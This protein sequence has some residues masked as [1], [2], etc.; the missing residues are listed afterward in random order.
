MK[1]QFNVI[2][3]SFII[4]IKVLIFLKDNLDKNSELSYYKPKYIKILIFFT[5]K[6]TI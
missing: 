1:D 3:L 4:D 2:S 5:K 6:I